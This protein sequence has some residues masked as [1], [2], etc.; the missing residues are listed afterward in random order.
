MPRKT[1]VVHDQQIYKLD[2]GATVTIDFVVGKRPKFF[3]PADGVVIIGDHACGGAAPIAFVPTATIEPEGG[4][5]LAEIRDFQRRREEPA[6]KKPLTSEDIAR[7]QGFNPQALSFEN[8]SGIAAQ[9]P[10][11]VPEDSIVE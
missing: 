2:D 5:S 10:P 3:Q 11:V 1:K 7:E 8:L 4:P 9:M 6:R